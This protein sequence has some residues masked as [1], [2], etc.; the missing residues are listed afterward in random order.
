MKPRIRTVML[1]AEDQSQTVHFWSQLLETEP[2]HSGHEDSIVWLK[3]QEQGAVGVGI[4]RVEHHSGTAEVHL[5]IQVD[6]LDV[7][8]SKVESLGGK[9]HA[10]HTLADGFEWRICADPAGNQFC[11]FTA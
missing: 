2:V 6:N 3:P 7:T 9:L 10:R 11:I 5:D 4:Q 1:N 8:Q